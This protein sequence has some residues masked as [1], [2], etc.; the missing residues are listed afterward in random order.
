MCEGEG[1][2]EG[3]SADVSVVVSIL[4][5]NGLWRDTFGKT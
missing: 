5:S 4:N 1:E 2:G 3:E